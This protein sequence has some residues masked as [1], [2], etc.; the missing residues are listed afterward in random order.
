MTAFTDGKIVSTLL[1][2]GEQDRGDSKA[3]N[4]FL[5]E[6][7]TKCVHFVIST[8]CMYLERRIERA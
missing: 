2:K 5:L 1:R 3:Y 8:S 4:A 6:V 7:C